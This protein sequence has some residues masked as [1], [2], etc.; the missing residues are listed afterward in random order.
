MT[1]TFWQRLVRGERHLHEQPDW[2]TFAGLQWAD[3]IMDVAVTDRFHAK[4]GRSI[5]RWTLHD[6][7]RRR[8]VYLKRHY[9]LPWWHGL[10]ATVYPGSGWSPAVQEWHHLEWARALERSGVNVMYSDVSP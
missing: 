1:Q 3:H 2:A 6:G 4:Q 10:L 5:G 9:R 8:V 7:P